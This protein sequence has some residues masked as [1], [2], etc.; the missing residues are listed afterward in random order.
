MTQPATLPKPFDAAYFQDPY[1]TYARLRDQGAV[2][3][4]ALP[5][6]SPVWL[7]V[8]E[9]DVRAGL[10]DHRLSVNKAHAGSGYKGFSLPA[11][12]DAN[13][14]NIDPPDHLRLRRLVSKAFTPRRI[15]RL[16]Q[17]VQGLC[18]QLVQQV[19][20]RLR[21]DG[22][23]DVIDILAAPLPLAVIGEL[24]GIPEQDR[25][26]F[27]TWVG[28]M[29]VPSSAHDVTEAI[30]H[31]HRYL[32]D[33]IALRRREDDGNLI[34]GLITVRDNGD[35]LS[36]NELLSLAFLILSAGTDST[37]HVIS[38][39]ILTL[40]QHP[41]EL[42]A[43]RQDPNLIPEAVE[44]LLRYTTPN[45]TAIRRFPTEDIT[46]AKTSIPAGDTVLLC[47]ASAHR[48]PL[49]YPEPDRFDI[50]RTDKAHLTLGHGLHYCLGAPLAR[51]QVQ[52]AIATLIQRLPCLELAVPAKDLAWRRSFR[53]HA[54]QQLPVTRGS[55]A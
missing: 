10:T 51:M 35:Q 41:D 38:S 43:I 47:L 24:L 42:E 12:L 3:R 15:D 44:E 4:V 20:Q 50:R 39:G 6:S 40:L 17:S 49:R 5:D 9:A 23:A 27:A 2:H 25:Q 36:E 33:L 54:L 28:T 13:L 21:A 19:V 45:H 18:T 16:R 11:A 1:S 7:V 8:K 34:S 32:L 26:P 55:S 29:Q 48:D 30:A 52:V 14:L 53:S 37:Q 22:T 46:I 31:I